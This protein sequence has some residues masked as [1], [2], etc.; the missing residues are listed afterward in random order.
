[1]TH[2]SPRQCPKILC[3]SS[4]QSVLNKAPTFYAKPQLKGTK[5]SPNRLDKSTLNRNVVVPGTRW[6]PTIRL[7]PRIIWG[8]TMR[9]GPR[10]RL[11]LRIRL[12][13]GIR[14][15][16]KFI[17]NTMYTYMAFCRLSTKRLS[18]TCHAWCLSTHGNGK[19]LE[20]EPLGSSALSCKCVLIIVAD[21]T[22][23]IVS[24]AYPCLS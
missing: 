6:G 16:R 5:Q 4:S 7:G 15:G 1:M 10:I 14:R 11:G 23:L 20:F 12:G 3:K 9:L 13:S 8:P 2:R 22:F 17:V 24:L 19:A 18:Q 21:L